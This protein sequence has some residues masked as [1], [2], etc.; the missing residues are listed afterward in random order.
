MTLF[1]ILILLF[2]LAISA[3]DGFAAGLIWQDSKQQGGFMRLVAWSAVVMSACG[4]SMILAI[5]GGFWAQTVGSLSAHSFQ[6]LMS[7]E[8]LLIM[9]LLLISG[10]IITIHSYIVAYRE[11]DFVSVGTAAYNTFAMG[12]NIYQAA[13]GGISNA[14]TNVGSLF[15]GDS[16]SDED[17]GL[18]MIVI[19]IIL[20]L[21]AGVAVGFTYGMWSLGRKKSQS[22][23]TQLA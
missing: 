18:T 23:N 2:T 3:W 20:A 17:N 8:Y 9:P 21:S 5:L 16:D 4:F 12:N 14:W 15:K 10:V 22:W 19:G 6:I 11:R 13:D 7:F 1:L